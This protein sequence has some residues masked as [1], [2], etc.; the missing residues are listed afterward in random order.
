M[1]NSNNRLEE[2]GNK[3]L[4]Y[5]FHTHVEKIDELESYFDLNVIP[6]INI[7]NF[8]E[9]EIIKKSDKW[10]KY[11]KSINDNFYI[12]IGVHPFDNTLWSEKTEIFYNNLSKYSSFVGEIGMDSCWSNV[13]KSIQKSNFERS[14]KFA[15]KNNFPVI[16]HTKNMEGEIY[17]I[18]RKYSLRF[19]VHWYSCENYIDEYISLGCYFT[20]GPALLE[21]K[22]IRTLAKKVP[23]DKILIE[24][25]GLSA[26]KWLYNKDVSENELRYYLEITIDE[27]AQIKGISPRKMV[28]IVNTN[29]EFLLR[30]G[31][32]N[33]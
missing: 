27:I 19:I 18:I 6:I 16:L 13:D 17:D 28:D 11:S 33:G 9:W 20:F 15:Y 30:K 26:L 4:L 7:S 25:D 22:N 23:L 3:A 14:L 24:T 2:K 32:K 21:D 5:D 8:H 10:E 29:S 12:S 1:K 31:D